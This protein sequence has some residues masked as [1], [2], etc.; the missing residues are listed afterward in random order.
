[1]IASSSEFMGAIIRFIQ[2][3]TAIVAE[4][5][6]N[7]GRRSSPVDPD[8]SPPE[9]RL[10]RNKKIV[11]GVCCVVIV[12]A[13][14]RLVVATMAVPSPK[15]DGRPYEARGK[16]CAEETNKLLG[17]RG[18][19]VVIAWGASGHTTGLA[20]TEL[21][22][23][24]KTLGKCGGVSIRATETLANPAA[25]PNFERLT[26]E[27]LMAIINRY[28]G[29][30]AIVSFAGVPE[31]TS[32]DIKRWPSTAPKLVLIAAHDPAGKLKELLA[33]NV[34]ALAIVPRSN[35][36]PDSAKKSETDRERFDRHFEIVTAEAVAKAP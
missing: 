21:G 4:M 2:W 11:A 25:G 27:R 19:V 10:N 16:V 18:Q 17:G 36:A 1:M 13:C 7:L 5:F 33:A 6:S 8:Q 26:S 12:A 32:E 22:S 29:M 14:V 35:P 31:L 30:N 20:A 3:V 24:R 23:F 15:F 28:P 34:A 9:S